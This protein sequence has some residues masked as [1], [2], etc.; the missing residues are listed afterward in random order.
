MQRGVVFG[1]IAYVLWGVFP[2]Y[3]KQVQAVPPMEVLAHRM[4]W[5]LVFVAAVL[6]ALGRWAWLR[7]VLSQPFMLGW[8]ALS[9]IVVS[10]NWGIYI[11]AVAAGH[12]VDASLG[13]F[14]N[15]LLNVLI[16]AV[17]LGERLR[18]AHWVAVLLAAL[19]SLAFGSRVVSWPDVV[20]G[21]LHPDLD[22]IESKLGRV[23]IGIAPVISGGGTR[24]KNLYLG[25]TG[26]VVVTTPLGNEGIGFVD[27][28]DA[29]I[30]GDGRSMASALNEI[31]RD[32]DRAHRL[33]EQAA[34]KVREEFCP[35]R[36]WALYRERVFSGVPA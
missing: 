12:I 27:G 23:R 31:A 6:A 3:F 24:M 25:A 13:Y 33:G 1:L 4:I 8:F 36:I 7:T 21:V 30:R 18:P 22:D 5:S 20:A 19:A 28:H 11:W 35:D 14:I 32:P 16:G 9:A 34:R 29:I 26:R 2:I 10:L 17:F 15:P